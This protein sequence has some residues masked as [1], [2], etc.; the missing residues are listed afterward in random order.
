MAP[1]A[2]SK[3]LSEKANSFLPDICIP[4]GGSVARTNGYVS[5]NLRRTFNA[6][7]SQIFGLGT[8]AGYS[9]VTVNVS[10]ATFPADVTINARPGLP[11]N[12]PGVTTLNRH[13]TLA[14]LP[15]VAADLVFWYPAADIAGNE[16]AYRAAR[17]SGA[18]TAFPTTV[19]PLNHTAPVSGATLISGDWLLLDADNDFDGMPNDWETAHGLNPDNASVSPIDDDRDGQTNIQEFVADTDPLDSADLLR[20]TGFTLAPDFS[21]CT[22]TWKS[23]ATRRYR[24]KE[25]PDLVSAWTPVLDAVVP[26]GGATTMRTL[27]LAVGTRGFFRVCASHSPTP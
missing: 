13:W 1:P 14:A 2:K 22:L 5:G 26:D 10:A 27:V 17:Y 24:T 3:F 4:S 19:D 18:F 12:Y 7:G 8:A 15:D 25:T 16:N 6:A 20:I 21:S 23:R 11:Q 9:P